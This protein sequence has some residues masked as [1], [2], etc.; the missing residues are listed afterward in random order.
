MP[1][2]LGGVFWPQSKKTFSPN[3]IRQK[4][5]YRRCPHSLEITR[6]PTATPSNDLA[7]SSDPYPPHLTVLDNIEHNAFLITRPNQ[8]LRCSITAT[9]DRHLS[10]VSQ[11]AIA[12]DAAERKYKYAGTR[13]VSEFASRQGTTWGLRPDHLLTSLAGPCN[14][15]QRFFH[16]S[17]IAHSFL[18]IQVLAS[19]AGS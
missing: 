17:N 13:Q 2:F 15:T 14:I 4:T 7:I 19:H 9:F 8:C 3:A 6:L 11:Y 1:S 10:T 18:I 12:N 16:H 5:L